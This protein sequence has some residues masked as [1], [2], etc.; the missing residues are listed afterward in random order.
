MSEGIKAVRW[1]KKDCKLFKLTDRVLIQGN[2]VEIVYIFQS[3]LN[4]NENS[5]SMNVK[6]PILLT[7]VY[8]SWVRM[9]SIN[10]FQKA[11]TR[12]K[13]QG[14][15]RIKLPVPIYF[16]GMHW[17][18]ISGKNVQTKSSVNEIPNCRIP[19]LQIRT[20]YLW[21]QW[22]LGKSLFFFFLSPSGSLVA[23]RYPVAFGKQ[24]F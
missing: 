13:K 21:F 22:K 5:V 1:I 2:T 9:E 6:Y 8:L 14:N 20:I 12:I 24:V 3:S 15:T 23:A 18:C 4:V 16:S 19:R 7:Q 11:K 10:T 17:V